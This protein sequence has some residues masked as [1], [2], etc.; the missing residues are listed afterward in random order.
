MYYALKKEVSERIARVFKDDAKVFMLYATI[1]ANC[2]DKNRIS[3]EVYDGDLY[4]SLTLR[5]DIDFECVQENPLE[6]LTVKV[7]DVSNLVWWRYVIKK[8]A[9]NGFFFFMGST[10]LLIAAV[11]ISIAIK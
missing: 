4:S 1:K 3:I 11:F 5:K 6:G 9:E 10:F 2:E 7:V 8:L